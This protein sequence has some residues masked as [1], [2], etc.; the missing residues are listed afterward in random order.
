MVFNVLW[1][2]V[3]RFVVGEPS[4]YTEELARYL[5][6]WVGL[7]GGSYAAGKNM[8]LAIDLVPA[9]LAGRAKAWSAIAI[10]AAILF[11]STAVLIVG[12]A[13][14]VALTLALEQ[15]SAAL[16]V[17]LGHV[18]LAVPASGCF[19]ALYA[20]LALLDAARDLRRDRL[21]K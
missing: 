21:W 1:Q 5:L 15:T 3:S 8:H 17:K 4:S 9:R 10:Q 20:A 12:G 11:F 14:L 6:I 7:L 16:Q 2:V 19:M 13:R 18:Y